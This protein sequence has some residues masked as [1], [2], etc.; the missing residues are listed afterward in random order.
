[1]LLRNVRHKYF[2]DRLL[3]LRGITLAKDLSYIALLS[4]L[5]G[6]NDILGSFND[7]LCGEQRASLL[8]AV[9]CGTSPGLA[10]FRGN[11]KK[12]LTL[13]KKIPPIFNYLT[14]FGRDKFELYL[15]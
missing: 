5:S 1:M 7:E 9:L 2:F 10:I 14:S 4:L 12:L 8:K 3:P 15:R 13:R 6:I 11:M